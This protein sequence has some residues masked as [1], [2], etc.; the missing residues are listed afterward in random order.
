M[1]LLLLSIIMMND[2]PVIKLSLTFLSGKF[3]T[4]LLL[5]S[6]LYNALNLIAGTTY[7]FY[8]KVLISLFIILLASFNLYDFF[9]S[10]KEEYG[11]I[12]NQLTKGIRNFNRNMIES[13]AD[14]DKK[15]W[16][17][18]SLFIL[19]IIIAVGEFLC[20][21][22]V[23]MITINYMISSNPEFS[24]IAFLYLALYS[25]GF[26]LPPAVAVIVIGKTDELFGVSEF[27]R[28]R[29]PLIKLLTGFIMIVLAIITL[30]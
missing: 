12:K 20:T 29:M 9:M 13:L 15:T 2:V 14:Y 10:R 24:F 5:G 3:I 11:K 16:L 27:I 30:F 21:G 23:Y 1:L 22:Q 19:G 7:L 6:L 28:E 17:F 4:F 26:I 8:S 25:F 18:I